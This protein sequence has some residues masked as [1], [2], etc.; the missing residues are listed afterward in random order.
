MSQGRAESLSNVLRKGREFVQCLKVAQR[1]C[2]MSQGRA[3]SL[4][5][6]SR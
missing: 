2:Q 5:K 1:V 4:S 3:E 6:V